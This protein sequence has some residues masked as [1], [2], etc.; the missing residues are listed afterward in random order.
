MKREKKLLK[1]FFPHAIAMSCMNVKNDVNGQ[2]HNISDNTGSNIHTPSRNTHNSYNKNTQTQ[3]NCYGNHT[4][5]FFKIPRW[6]LK[7]CAHP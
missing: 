5:R 2:Q 7:R 3:H 1:F 4:K 6:L